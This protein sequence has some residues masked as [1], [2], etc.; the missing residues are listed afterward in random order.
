MKIFELKIDRLKYSKFFTE[1]TALL[2]KKDFKNWKAIFTPNPEMCL[3]TLKDKEFLQA[4]QKADYLTSDGI[5]LYF[6]YQIQDNNYGSFINI[7]LFPYYF[8][9]LFFR[10]FYLYQKYGER[11]CGSDV[12]EDLVY[13]CEAKSIRIAILD[14]YYPNDVEKCLSQKYFSKNLL[15]VFPNLKFDH[16][17]Y[18]EKEK[19]S[20][21]EKISHSKAEI[22]F[23]TLWMKKQEL[24]VLDWLKKCKN[25]KLWLWVGSSF[26]YF[27]WFQKRAPKIFRDFWLEW[28]YRVF[29][30]PNKIKRLGRIYQALIVFPIKVLLYKK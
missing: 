10:K 26:D 23:S 19:N 21:F 1:I 30:S 14:P 28:L 24:S 13:F 7:L 11:I 25:L 16:Y 17:I 27:I 3:Q 12:T 9:N 6:W 5:G 29:T 22:L 20:I 15:K 2:Q 4:L 18:T 8:L